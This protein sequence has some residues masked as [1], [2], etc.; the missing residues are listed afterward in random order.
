[1][2]KIKKLDKEFRL[3]DS[4]VNCYGFR[5][6]TSGYQIEEYKRN[7]IG[8]YMHERGLGVIVKWDELRISGDAVY[9]KPI[10]NMNHQRAQ[11]T[12]DEVENGFLN[13]ASVG[14]IV[15]IEYSDALELKVPGQDGVTITKWYNR[16]CSLVDIPGNINALSLFDENENPLKISDLKGSSN[17]AEITNKSSV[18]KRRTHEENVEYYSKLNL[19]DRMSFSEL[20]EAGLLEDLKDFDIRLFDEKYKEEFNKQYVHQIVKE[21]NNLFKGLY[22][23]KEISAMEWNELHAKDILLELRERDIN[24]F[25]EVFRNQFGK[26]YAV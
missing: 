11:Q 21:K 16:E 26:E 8:Y 19:F 1:M 18:N 9:G 25:K 6:L 12:I 24:R 15:A 20:M 3:T 23:L 2:E 13:A 17:M 14:H 5:L 22:S 4:S 7:P 10:I